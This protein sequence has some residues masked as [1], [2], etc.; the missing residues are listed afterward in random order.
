MAES[1]KKKFTTLD[2]DSPSFLHYNKVF[3]EKCG[4]IVHLFTYRDFNL[5]KVVQHAVVYA[6]GRIETRFIRNYIRM[7][8][9]VIRTIYRVRH[10]GSA[11][12]KK[13]EA[14]QLEPLLFIDNGRERF[15]PDGTAV[16]MY[17]ETFYR[18]PPPGSYSVIIK[19][20]EAV[21]KKWDLA[22]AALRSAFSA[23]PVDRNAATVITGLKVIYNKIRR[24]GRFSPYELKHVRTFFHIFL[25][26][27]LFYNFILS[28]GQVKKCVFDNH[29]FNEPLILACRLRGIQTIELQ[30]GLIAANDMYYIYL[31]FVEKV[32]PLA[33][34]PDK[35]LVYGKFWQQ[36]LLRGH[37]HRPGSVLVAGNYVWNNSP[38]A[39]ITA[40]K[41]NVVFIGAQKNMTPFYTGY[42]VKLAA[43]LK[44]RHPG[45]NIVLKTHP[46]EKDPEAYRRALSHLENVK[47]VG[48]EASL[49]GILEGC[50][51]QVTYYST[52]LY[53][54]AGYGVINFAIQ[55]DSPF[56]P[57]CIEMVE[58][59]IA[60]PIYSGDDPVEMYEQQRGNM[61][62]PIREEFYGHLDR[63]LISG[64]LKVA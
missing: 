50:R 13:Y 14:P 34:F 48:N 40:G 45:W 64:V 53:D 3:A 31:P 11:L 52:T 7:P 37:E 2:S 5:L 12:R 46:S 59:G 62:L 41:E 32:A 57:Y 19:K 9:Q 30:H 27:F 38:P 39:Q 8:S 20:N 61:H 51:I 28:R 60:L 4:D 44:E 21:V 56:L 43:L 49:S 22:L 55:D 23:P 47:L 18:L 24:S 16:S 6:T 42:V 58:D 54:A 36:K 10:A 25:E 63:E 26:D 15:L 17:Y 29:Y 35:V 33:L 1:G